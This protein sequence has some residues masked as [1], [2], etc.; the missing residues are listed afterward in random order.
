MPPATF[1]CAHSP[2]GLAQLYQL[3]AAQC[4][5]DMGSGPYWSFAHTRHDAIDAQVFTFVGW[6]IC[7]NHRCTTLALEMFQWPSFWPSTPWPLCFPAKFTPVGEAINPGPHFAIT[8]ANPT[9]LRGKERTVYEL[10]RGIV[11]LAE[12]HLAPP[13]MRAACHSLRHMAT[14]DNR[15][16]WLLPR[17][18]PS[19]TKPVHRSVGWSLSAQ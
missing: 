16:W 17:A 9:G 11:N 15:R 5:C 2:E 19:G 8:V 3:S 7:A 4:V 13:G 18:G 10:P 1:A 12:T 6:P 14:E